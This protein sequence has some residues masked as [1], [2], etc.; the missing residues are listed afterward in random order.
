MIGSHTE[1]QLLLLFFKY[2]YS[3][4]LILQD[5]SVNWFETMCNF[6]RHYRQAQELGRIQY[7][8]AIQQQGHPRPPREDTELQ[9]PSTDPLMGNE[10]KW[11]YLGQL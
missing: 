2:Y 9:V 7:G 6:Q 11:L 3:K 1:K 10:N 4:F 5:T 8:Q